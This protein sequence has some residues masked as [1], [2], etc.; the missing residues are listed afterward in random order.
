MPIKTVAIVGSGF[1]GSGIAQVVSQAGCNVRLI[2]TS[3]ISLAKAHAIIGW[4]L[5]KLASKNL[6]KEP[7]EAIFSRIVC[8]TDYGAA[9]DVDLAIEAIYEDVELKQEL[10]GQLDSLCSP[11]TIL[12]SNTS[13]IPI[14]KLAAATK[15]AERVIGTHFFGPVP[16]MR[17][18]EVIPN[19]ATLPEVTDAVMAFARFV[20]KNPVLVKKDIPGFLM[21]RIFGAMSCEAMRLVEESA[22][23]IVDIDQG[24]CDGFNLQAGPLAISDLAGLDICANAFSIMHE[25]DPARFPEIPEILKRLVR[26]GK[27]GAKTGEGFYL[28]SPQGKRM[29]PAF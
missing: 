2:D 20:G 5:E 24:M 1:M 16:L 23:T 10:F 29:G 6:V 21:N 9:S 28:W 11:D 3:E 7:V 18:V 26:E 27:L 4:S 17:L 14:T 19:P 13:T 8:T 22:G 15:R 25:I 12:A